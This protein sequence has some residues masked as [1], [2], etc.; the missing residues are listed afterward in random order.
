MFHAAAVE[1]FRTGR[2]AFADDEHPMSLSSSNGVPSSDAATIGH[3]LGLSGRLTT[4]ELSGRS[5]SDDDLRA[6]AALSPSLRRLD[7]IDCRLPHSTAKTIR[8]LENLEF[9]FLVDCS[10]N[11]DIYDAIASLDNLV[12][13]RIVGANPSDEDIG[14]LGTIQRRVSVVILEGPQLTDACVASLVQM[15]PPSMLTL[16]DTQI[17]ADGERRL[18]EAFPDCH[19]AVMQP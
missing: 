3:T 12:W 9:L 14:R 6:I 7:L 4:L 17:S 13:L 18:R 10:L 2:M 16:I 5:L 1:R 11:S 19:L 8:R 15:P